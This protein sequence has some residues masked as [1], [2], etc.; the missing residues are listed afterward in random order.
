MEHSTIY[1]PRTEHSTRYYHQLLLVL[2]D[3]LNTRQTDQQTAT[4]LNSRAILSPSGKP[5][6]ASAVKQCLYKIRNYKEVPSKLHQALLQLAFDGV[7][8]ASQALILFA[9]RRQQGTL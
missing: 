8:R 6:T 7:L 2:I 9:P 4:L 1:H 5:W 3:A